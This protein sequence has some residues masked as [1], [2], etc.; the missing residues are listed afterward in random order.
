MPLI[1]GAAVFVISFVFIRFFIPIAKRLG[2]VNLPNDRSMHARAKPRGAGICFVG[3]SLIAL[4]YASYNSLYDLGPQMYILAAIG[5][6]YFAGLLDDLKD[7]SPLLKFAL[8][9]T[10]TVVLVSNDFYITTL[11]RFF[12]YDLVL[13]ALIA[14]PFTIFAVTGFTNA[15][16]LMDGLDGL[17]AM[18]SMIMLAVFAWIGFT[19]ND[20]FLMMMSVTFISA[21]GAFLLF[22]WY[23]AKV[24]MGDSGSLTLGFVISVL[25][26]HSLQYIQPLAMLFIVVLPVLDTF[27]VMTRRIQRS[28]S[29]FKADRTHMHHILFNR[30][31]DVPYTVIMLV[32]IQISFTIMGVQLRDADSFL[33][34]ILFGILFFIFLNLF[35]QRMKHRKIRHKGIIDEWGSDSR[36]HAEDELSHKLPPEA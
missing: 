1:L 20:P 25:G 28:L 16:N 22:N 21:L 36:R 19:H 24:F 35:D 5:I 17:A 10:A 30:Y 32:Y 15:L 4:G 27:I 8:I 2:F 14:I 3:A 11:G 7:I 34:L 12:G 6:V 9:I 31:E 29:P 13:P 18:I 33:T 26:I 23:P